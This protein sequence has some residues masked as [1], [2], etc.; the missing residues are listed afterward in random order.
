VSGPWATACDEACSTRLASRASLT[1]S[2]HLVALALNSQKPP[3]WRI[4]YAT[5][6]GACLRAYR[7]TLA[8]PGER[9]PDEEVEDEQPDDHLLWFALKMIAE[10]PERLPA[11]HGTWVRW[12]EA[13]LRVWWKRQQP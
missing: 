1:E 9:V 7:R 4:Y 11:E 3:R 13:A 2:A 8:D 10:L 6:A 12:A 5:R